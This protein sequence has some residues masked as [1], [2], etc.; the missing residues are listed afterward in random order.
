[1]LKQT[2]S[3]TVGPFFSFGLIREGE[4]TLA[5]DKT[6]GQRIILHG[7]VYDGSGT[8]INDAMIEIWQADSQGIFNHPDDPRCHQVDP[9]FRGFGRSGTRNQELQYSFKTVRPGPV[10]W[11]GDQLQAPHINMR[12]FAR[13]MLL[14]LITRVYFPDEPLNDHDPIL[15]SI[16]DLERRKT[17]IAVREDVDDAPTYRLDIRLQGDGETVFFNP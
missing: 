12:I 17:L 11:E 14:H 6:K 8:P 5:N 3:Q 4:N 2:P 16:E 1:M 15:S 10:P 9:A 7:Y 13:G